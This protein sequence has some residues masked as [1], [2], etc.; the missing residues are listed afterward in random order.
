LWG[1]DITP[2][3]VVWNG[4]EYIDYCSGIANPRKPKYFKGKRVLIREITNPKIFA[5]YSEKEQ[6]HDPSIIVV[7]DNK[8]K[9]FPL[10]GILN[11]N[12]A[13]FFHFNASPKA[14]K[15]AFPKILVKDIKEFPLPDWSSAQE[16][17]PYVSKIIKLVNDPDYDSDKQSQEEVKRLEEEI[18]IMVYQLYGLT[19][20]DIEIIEESVGK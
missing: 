17:E 11:S 12:L 8:N 4:Q 10:L 6:Y 19:K 5:G 3:R 9:I 15:G 2:F 13:T 16:I 14:T 18:N 20:E 7:L 1:Q